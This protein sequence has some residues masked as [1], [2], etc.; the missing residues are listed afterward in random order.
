MF[1]D[2]LKNCPQNKLLEVPKP[3]MKAAAKE[4]GIKNMRINPNE[5]NQI[6]I[7]GE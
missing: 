6:I 1:H 3:I 2:F 7:K 4:A 5:K